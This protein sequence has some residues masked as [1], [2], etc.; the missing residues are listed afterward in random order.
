MRKENHT[1]YF[2]VEGDTEKWYLD[3]LQ[4]TINNTPEAKF[5]VKLDSKIQKDPLARAKGLTVLG[6][7]QIVHVFDRESEDEYHAKQFEDTLKRMKS[8]KKLGKD[9]VYLLGYSN[10]TFELWMILHKADCNRTLNYRKQ[11]LA[12][13]NRAFGE[14]FE[15]LDEYKHEDNFKRVLNK[16][17]LDDVQMAIVRSEQIMAH[18]QEAG[19]TLHNYMGYKYYKEN[20]ALSIWEA[21][22]KILCDCGLMN[23]ESN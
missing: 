18:N 11:Y 15:D 9:I 21:I 20:P 4:K 16:L 2:S 13:L 6:K 23:V 1:Y 19:F 7:T 17:T 22:K 5:K 14:C 12:P 10:F 8:T 3:W